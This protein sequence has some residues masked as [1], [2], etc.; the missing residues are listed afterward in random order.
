MDFLFE[1]CYNISEKV[2]RMNHYYTNNT[3]LKSEIRTIKYTYKNATVSFKT[4]SGVFSKE[5]IDFGTN[6]LL[7]SLED[8]STYKKLLDVGCGYGT[9]GLS[10]AKAYN[11]LLVDMVDI[12][13]RAVRLAN[14]NAKENK[15]DNAV[16]IT[17]NIYENVRG[18]YDVVISNPPIRAGKKVVFEIVEKAK[19]HL[20]LNGFIYV[21]IQKKQGAPSLINKMEEVYG[22][23]EIINKE[24]GYYII[25]SVKN[26]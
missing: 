7:N 21:V 14:L 26:N 23:I 8:L 6:V 19:E 13:E 17:S 25:K 24:K 22:N 10:I 18:T 2:K 1:I 3:D 4:D 16:A 12:N 20:N 15:I 5:H 11:H 9:I